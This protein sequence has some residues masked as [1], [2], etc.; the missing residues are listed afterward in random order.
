MLGIT[1]SSF[2]WLA[3][4]LV[5]VVLGILIAFQIEEWREWL[6]NEKRAENALRSILDDLEIGESEYLQW[7]EGLIQV[8][9]QTE[10]LIRFSS[11]LPEVSEPASQEVHAALQPINYRSRLWA[12]TATAFNGARDNGDLVFVRDGSLRKKITNY[13][14]TLEPY[15]LEIRQS[16]KTVERAFTAELRRVTRPVL[17][18][19]FLK[20][21]NVS[22]ELD[23]DVGELAEDK[24]FREALILYHV[25]LGSLAQRTQFGRNELKKLRASIED[26]LATK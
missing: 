7:E 9:A 12:P 25:R 13:F 17:A 21:D 19:D 23:M 4:E 6:A 20:T 18:K 16:F 15:L 3:A 5:V 11:L 10:I 26:Y 1:R 8:R 22:R 2:Q 14:D 24:E